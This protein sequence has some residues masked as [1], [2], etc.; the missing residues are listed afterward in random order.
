M[1]K[2][3][4]GAPAPVAGPWMPMRISVSLTPVRSWGPPA[5]VVA[6]A[7]PPDDGAAAVPP[8]L[9]A[10]VAVG[11]CLRSPFIVCVDAVICASSG[12]RVGGPLEAT[13]DA[14]LPG[15]DRFTGTSQRHGGPA[16]QEQD[17]ED[18]GD[19]HPWQTVLASRLLLGC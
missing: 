4:A 14:A 5:A 15:R 9:A 18:S 13:D 19:E 3:G 17:R 16:Q 7:P 11:S 10:V 6:V 8:A 12:G 2:L 1:S